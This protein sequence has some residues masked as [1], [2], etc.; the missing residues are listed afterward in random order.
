MKAKD[1]APL[2]SDIAYQ[3]ILDAL[4]NQSLPLGAILTQQELTKVAGVPIGPVRDALK[5]LENDGIVTVHPRSGIEVIRKST[6]LI[7]STYQFRMLIERDAVRM[8]AVQA[9]G[10]EVEQ[11]IALH[12]AANAEYGAADPN[13][14][15]SDHMT[16]IE[17]AFHLTIVAAL[18]NEMINLS[19]QRLTLMSQ[20]IKVNYLVLPVVA[21]T[22]VAEHLAV[23]YAIQNRDA[24]AAEAAIRQHLLKAL[25]RNLGLN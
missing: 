3:R 23:L 8:Y 1:A 25:N 13:T 6:D 22:S 9:S 7:R 18:G 12:E 16:T 19:Y 14:S 11:L 20:I 24:D 10:A 4:M 17:Q 15:V 2:L 21:R 5:T